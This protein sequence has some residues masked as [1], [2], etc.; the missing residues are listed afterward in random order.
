MENTLAQ[1][2][3]TAPNGGA[4]TAQGPNVTASRATFRQ[5]LMAW[6]PAL[7]ILAGMPLLALTATRYV[8][9]PSMKQVFA[10]QAAAD[11]GAAPLF[12]AKIPL[13]ASDA[14]GA[15]AGFRSLALLGA[16]SGFKKNVAQNKAKLADVAT[17][18]LIGKTISDLDKPGALG[19]LR[20]QLLADF[21][22]ALG[23]PV[24]KEVYI[25]VWPQ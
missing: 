15:H 7:V 12:L 3:R 22:R 6:L 25:A 14:K 5:S 8:M 10:Q 21:N 20:A 2:T 9:L 13:D 11:H 24:V 17:I 19:A 1:I 16:N 23:G 18:D 4:E